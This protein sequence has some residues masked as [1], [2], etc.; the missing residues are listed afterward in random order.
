MAESLP[1][2][3]SVVAQTSPH[4]QT[5]VEGVVVKAIFEGLSRFGSPLTARGITAFRRTFTR[6]SE[7]TLEDAKSAGIGDRT[8]CCSGR[9][10]QQ[11]DQRAVR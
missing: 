2:V 7:K 6:A 5:F 8:S 4:L 9:R 3:T 1:F 10:G 11:I